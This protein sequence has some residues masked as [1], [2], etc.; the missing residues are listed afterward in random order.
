MIGIDMQIDVGYIDDENE[1][2]L[3]DE[4]ILTPTGKGHYDYHNT[5]E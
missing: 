4:S 5:I 1:E 2:G 3:S